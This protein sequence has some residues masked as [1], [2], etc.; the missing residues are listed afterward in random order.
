MPFEKFRSQLT[1]SSISPTDA[2]RWRTGLATWAR[3]TSKAKENQRTQL[4][5]WRC[6]PRPTSANNVSPV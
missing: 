1:L 3:V 2:R 6:L 4:Q 5:K